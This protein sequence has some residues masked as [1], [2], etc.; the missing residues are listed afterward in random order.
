MMTHHPEVVKKAQTEIDEVI[1]SSQLPTLQDRPNLPYIDCI[2]KEVMRY[3]EPLSVK[4][5][6]LTH[7]L[8]SILL[9]RLVSNGS[10]IV[11]SDN[12]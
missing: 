4:G 8:E 3:A 6:T 5:K 10:Q 9:F 2:V 11:R 7:L 1:G 12:Q